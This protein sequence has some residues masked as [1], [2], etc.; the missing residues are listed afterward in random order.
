MADYTQAIRLIMVPKR[1]LP[2]IFLPYEEY[3]RRLPDFE[4]ICDRATEIVD[5]RKELNLDLE[6]I[7]FYGR[8]AHRGASNRGEADRV[9]K[10]YVEHDVETLY[11]KWIS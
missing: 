6:Q 7:L 1:T 5:M 8:V 10:F 3:H 11:W 2:M 4:A 9:T